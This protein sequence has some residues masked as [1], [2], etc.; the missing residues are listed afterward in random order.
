MVADRT[1][2]AGQYDLIEKYSLPGSQTPLHRHTRYWQLLYVL[3]GEFTVWAGENKVVF[4]SGDNILIPVGTPQMVAVLSNNPAHGLV[5]NTPSGP[6]RLITAMG[7]RDETET[8]DMARIACLWAEMGYETLG[9]P[10]TLP[11][12]ATRT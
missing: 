5:V 9:P 8:L 6:A 2:T 3:E 11:S 1:T 10:G 4:S 12:L 7:M